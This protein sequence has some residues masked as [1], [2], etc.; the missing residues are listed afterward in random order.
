MIQVLLTAKS[1]KREIKMERK[2]QTFCI[3]NFYTC[4]GIVVII[5]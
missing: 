3:I 4:Q 5:I 2:I 1:C